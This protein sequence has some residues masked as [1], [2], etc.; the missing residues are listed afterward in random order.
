MPG[1]LRATQAAKCK[2]RVRH[3]VQRAAD[4]LKVAH[5]ILFFQPEIR[6]PYTL[7]LIVVVDANG[8][9]IRIDKDGPADQDFLKKAKD[10]A[11]HWQ[12]THP[13]LNGKPVN[14]SFSIDVTFQP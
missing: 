12:S 7:H 2:R 11:K 13:S 14:A 8:K 3:D 1:R 6:I 5:K 4:V 10:A 9:V